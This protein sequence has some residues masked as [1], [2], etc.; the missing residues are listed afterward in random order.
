MDTARAGDSHGRPSHQPSVRTLAAAVSL[1]LVLSAAGPRLLAQD[2]SRAEGEAK[3]AFDT[4]RFQEAGEKYARAAESSPTPERKSDLAFQSGWAYFIAGNSKAAR[5]SLKTAFLAR[6]DLT[7]VADFYSPDFVKLAQTVRTEV[8]GG[9][10]APTVDVAETKRS[11][12]EKIADGKTAEALYDLK[13]VETGS[14]PEVQRLLA[15]AY[16]KLGR[17]PEADAARRRA[18]DLEKGLVTS[19]PIAAQPPGAPPNSQGPG[20]AA[21]AGPVLDSAEAALRNADFRGARGLASRALEIDPKSS[22]AHRILGDAALGLGQEGDAEREQTASLVL[23]SS[24]SRA[25][26]GLGRLAERQK[27]WNTAASHYRRAL[28]LSGKNVSAALG[29]GRSM[30]EL[31]D[32]TA[33]RIAFGRAIEI[34]PGSAEAHN[35]FGVFLYRSDQPERAVG[36]LMEAVRLAPARAVYHENLGRAFRRRQM[37]KESERELAEAARLAP[38]ETTVWIALGDIRAEQKKADEAANAYRSALDLDPANELAATGLAGSL[39]DAGR[40][41]DAE[42][43][44][45]RA[46]ESNANSAVLWNNLGVV[47]TR[48]GSFAPA[49][50]AFRKA[51]EE[52]ASLEAA[53]TNL[54]RAEQL[55]ALDRAGS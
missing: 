34:E 37:V 53:K 8:A 33:A 45:V 35:D 29:L 39:A 28:E 48:R 5:E 7:V 17:G 23:D 47:R 54:A 16:D 42:A 13:K 49:V 30:D 51:I 44:L 31:K 27:K 24:N 26:L 40:L 4:G 9:V 25:E 14:D 20:A 11:A 46:L 41:P 32:S 38:N 12:R 43:A 6:P 1:L 22:D 50:L 3:R 10:N 36:E 55:F 21:A 2:A 19:G 52:D 15:E 18:N